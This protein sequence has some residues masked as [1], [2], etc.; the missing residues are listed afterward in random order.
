[1]DFP[2][3]SG[4]IWDL[5]SGR[6]KLTLTGHID[7][8]LGLAISSKHTYM[9]SAGDDKLVKCWDLEQNK[10]IR[11]YDGHLSS[12]Y[13]LALHPTIDVSL[14][15]GV[16]DI[17]SKMQIRTLSGHENTVCSVFTRPTG[18][19]QIDNPNLAKP[20]NMKARD[21]D[22]KFSACIIS[23]SEFSSQ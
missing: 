23:K 21:V 7:Q 5:A 18:V 1:M 17:R 19:I 14:T 11:S 6:L 15:G 3:D 8:V 13:S 10:V 2:E 22:G 9:F 4:I 12:V 16:W 20:K